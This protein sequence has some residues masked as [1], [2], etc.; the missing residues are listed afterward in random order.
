M[1]HNLDATVFVYKEKKTG[2]I[3]CEYLDKARHLEEAENWEHIATL[4]PRMWIQCHWMDVERNR[5]DFK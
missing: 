1:T 4:E 3:R 2:E 5:D